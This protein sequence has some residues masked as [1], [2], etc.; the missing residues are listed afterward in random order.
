MLQKNLNRI[1]NI[2]LPKNELHF[3]DVNYNK[4]LD[5]YESHFKINKINGE[6]TPNY[7]TNKIYLERIQTHYPNIKI[8]ILL[9]N[10]VTRAISHWN[11]F[12]QIKDKSEKWGWKYDI[13]LINSIEKNPTILSNGNYYEQIKYVYELFDKDNVY[14]CINEKFQEFPTKNLIKYV[15]LLVFKIKI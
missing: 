7:M 5:W 15:N 12:N 2:F 10:P 3:F 4:G 9:R 8:I 11:H 13:N 6:K 14:I 1:N